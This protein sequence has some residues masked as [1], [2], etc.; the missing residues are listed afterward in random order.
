MTA[1]SQVTL[2]LSDLKKHIIRIYINRSMQSNLQSIIEDLPLG[3][4]SHDISLETS[5][6]GADI[7][8]L[9]VGAGP[10][11]ESAV[12]A[13]HG[14]TLVKLRLAAA[15]AKRERVTNYAGRRCLTVSHIFS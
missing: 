6:G 3:P 9:L 4:I 13:S 1:N 11:S 8:E 14:V 10:E 5:N 2:D 15:I 7:T 12:S